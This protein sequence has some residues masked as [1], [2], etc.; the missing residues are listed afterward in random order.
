[1]DEEG[2]TLAFQFYNDNFIV[3]LLSV[4]IR[5]TRCGGNTTSWFEYD[6]GYII[7]KQRVGRKVDNKIMWWCEGGL[8]L[9]GSVVYLNHNRRCPINGSTETHSSGKSKWNI[10]KYSRKSCL[11]L[12]E[13]ISL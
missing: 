2:W 9:L 7:M 11:K 4:T 6:R 10:D 1:M 5:Q 3:E 12:K 8:S 13:N